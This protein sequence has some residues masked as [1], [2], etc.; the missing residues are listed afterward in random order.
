MDIESAYCLIPVHPQ[1]R[2]C[3][4][5]VRCTLIPCSCLGFAR[6]PKSSMRL[7]TCSTGCSCRRGPGQQALSGRLHCHRSRRFSRV[8][9]GPDDGNSALQTPGSPSGSPGPTTCL[10]FLRIE[11]NS[12]TGQLRLPD[13]KLQRLQAILQEWGDR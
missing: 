9:G 4:G 1:N 5:T 6:C 7:P 11:I 10:T 13:D 2:P 8:P 3:C 12:C